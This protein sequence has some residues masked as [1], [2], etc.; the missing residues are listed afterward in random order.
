LKASTVAAS[1]FIIAGV[2]LASGVLP[3]EMSSVVS[4]YRIAK[5]KTK[6]NNTT[7][8]GHETYS[9]DPSFCTVTGLPVMLENLESRAVEPLENGEKT[10]TLRYTYDRVWEV[11]KED[12]LYWYVKVT[13]YYEAASTSTPPGESSPASTS[14]PTP[15]AATLGLNVIGVML[16]ILGLVTIIIVNRGRRTR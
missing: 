13:V 10:F 12:D 5:E 9:A 3:L 15:K 8:F 7:F 2:L 16:I 6:W 1:V 14:A 11:V 4:Y